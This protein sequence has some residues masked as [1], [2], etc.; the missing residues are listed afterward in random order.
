MV[1][2][3][4]ETNVRMNAEAHKM[5][6]GVTLFLLLLV[7]TSAPAEQPIP[8]R[9]GP[10][11]MVFDADNAML[12]YLRVGKIEVLRGI[13]APVRDRF[14]GTV[15][16][17]VTNVKVSD[18][19]DKFTVSFDASCRERDIDFSW[20]GRIVGDTSGQ[21]VFTF[22]GE[23]RSTFMRNRIGFCIL[24]DPSAAGQRW[25]IEDTNGA[26]ARGRFPA[27]ISPHQPARNIRAISHE[28][29]PGIWASVRC[30]GDVF[31]MEDQRNWTDASFKT[32]CT[33]LEVPYPVRIAK[34]TKVTH[35]VQVSLEGNVSR[36]L[37]EA[38]KPGESVT[39]TLED[40]S[41]SLHPLPRIGLQVSSQV[42]TLRAIDIA[43]LKALNLD[44]LRV[45][46]TPAVDS[47][48]EI[49]R[50]ATAQANSLCVR[51]HIGLQ[52]GE[53]AADELERLVAAIQTT[54]PPVSAWIILAADRE[55]FRLAR[56]SLGDSATGALIGVGEDTN[57]T[58]LNRNRPTDADVQVVSYGLNPQCHA[59]DNSTMIENLDIQGD[60]VRSARQFINDHRLLISPITLK[61]QKVNRAPLSGQ[62]PSN[63][64]ARQPTLFA[65]G[66]TL[67][68]IKYLSEAG[69]EGLTYYETVGWKG[70]MSSGPETPFP[71]HFRS[72]PDDVF[73]MYHVLRDVGVFA[74]GDV[75]SV[76][77]TD[78][79]S[80]VA[81]ALK[82]GGRTR[83]LAAN[84]THRPRMVRI[85]GLKNGT[86]RVF[87]L[88]SKN[89]K[90]ATRE[91]EA[92]L[93]R[94][95]EQTAVTQED[96]EIRLPAHGI[97]RI[98]Q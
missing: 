21:V 15:I 62:L 57:F 83:L 54:Q 73:P 94:V 36:L 4:R 37:A 91:P 16:P 85:R 19:G 53:K 66:W 29:T 68:S 80:V 74:N 20:Q 88:D 65:A 46:I 9:A 67:G 18:G 1:V 11:T 96:L 24:H 82:K 64:D 12:R 28:L 71:S 63:V 70:I 93:R 14:W 60:T 84:L 31:E 25:V 97:A 50:R 22:D 44:H 90:S 58:E 35:K 86:A 40:G 72:M 45:S 13:N 89:L 27:F 92:F 78:A 87:R 76:R 59:S 69:V 77:S 43:R 42:A 81:L 26:K 32:Y 95:G 2:H 51:L 41:Q 52:L 8:L 38:V 56:Q 17:K 98:D 79:M 55:T 34:G 47:V 75:R 49:L 48:K 7:G 39:L 61:V 5:K 6:Y 3:E 30:E 10:L 23:A 33:P